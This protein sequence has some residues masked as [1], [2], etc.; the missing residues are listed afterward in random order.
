[1]GGGGGGLGQ[2]FTGF[3]CLDFGGNCA[4]VCGLCVFLGGLFLSSVA[5][6]GAEFLV[7]V[8]VDVIV[9]FIGRGGHRWIDGGFGVAQSVLALSS[10]AASAASV[11]AA[12]HTRMSL[13]RARSERHGLAL[14]LFFELPGAPVHHSCTIPVIWNLMSSRSAAFACSPSGGAR[15]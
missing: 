3:L 15:S 4:R 10:L 1:M 8:D 9:P 11:L 6:D 13:S 12:M 14:H 2:L 5:F 7:D